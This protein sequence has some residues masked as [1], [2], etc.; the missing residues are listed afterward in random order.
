M[1][2][3]GLGARN[4]NSV[5]SEISYHLVEPI[6]ISQLSAPVLAGPQTVAVANVNA[7]YVGAQV[8]CDTGANTEIIT[9]TAV[10]ANTIAASFAYS[11]LANAP[12]SGATFPIQEATD[13]IFT[14][15]EMLGYIS[16]AQ[17]DFLEAV[18]CIFA[19]YTQDA[20]AGSTIQQM[21]NSPTSPAIELNRVAASPIGKPITSLVRAGG[22]V[23]ATFPAPHGFKAGQTFWVQN[24]A[25]VSFA[26]VFQVVTAPPLTPDV[27]T[28]SQAGANATSTPGGRAVTWIRLYE[29]TQEELS[30][31]NR[32]WRTQTIAMP[33]AFYEDRVGLYRWGLDGKISVGVPLELLLSVRDT[34][35]LI[36]TDGFLVPDML[37]HYVKYRVLEFC[38]TKDGVWQ[39]SQRADY[40][41][42]RYQRGVATVQRFING[43]GVGA[44]GEG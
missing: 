8:I 27:L 38:F 34:Q 37:L 14:Q 33:S 6:V 35:N 12:L 41:R 9:L 24:P 40:C 42:G 3:P 44:Q 43:M 10:G 19:L 21:P 39:D 23:T 17:N 11:H 31:A 2:S 13:P 30:M 26:G 20:M 18:P 1:A 16:R 4:V 22:T 32:Q 36:L 29:L 28:Y 5:L 25:D 7:M 15:L